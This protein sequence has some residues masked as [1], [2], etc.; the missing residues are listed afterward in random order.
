MRRILSARS[1]VALML[2]VALAA[3]LIAGTRHVVERKIRLEQLAAEREEREALKRLAEVLRP[4]PLDVE[5]FMEDDDDP[6]AKPWEDVRE[7]IP[8]GD[9]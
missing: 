1:L 4:P 7:D 8:P 5:P 2:G 3:F 9:R 6:E